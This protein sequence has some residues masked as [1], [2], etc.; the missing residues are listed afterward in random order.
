MSSYTAHCLVLAERLWAV[1]DS[2]LSRI[3][4]LNNVAFGPL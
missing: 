1:G 2:I 3:H 4:G